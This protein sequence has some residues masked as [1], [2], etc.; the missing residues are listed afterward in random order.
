MYVRVHAVCVHEVH[1][2]VCMYAVY[3]RYVCACACA[4]MCA[5]AVCVY[6]YTCTCVRCTCIRYGYCVCMCVCV[7]LHV[8][9]PCVLCVRYTCACM[10][11]LYVCGGM[12][13]HV[14]VRAWSMC[15]C[16]Y[17]CVGYLCMHGVHLCVWNTCV[18]GVWHVHVRYVCVHVHVWDVCA[19]I[20]CVGHVCICACVGVRCVHAC[21]WGT[22]VG[23]R[24]RMHVRARGT[25]V[26]RCV[27]CVCVHCMHGIC[28]WGW[29][30]CVCGWG[31]AS[32]LKTL[33]PECVSLA[34]Q[35]PA[36]SRLLGRVRPQAKAG[37]R[38]KGM[39]ASWQGRT[40]QEG[41]AVAAA[42]AAG[43]WGW[44]CL[45]RWGPNSSSLPSRRWAA[46]L[47]FYVVTSCRSDSMKSLDLNAKVYS[48]LSEFK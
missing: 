38:Q 16:A 13:V 20:A 17:A 29:G 15:V 14:H 39:R 4:C 48:L 19:C 18:C 26:C 22:C 45:P 11:G 42:G 3:M 34:L 24:G 43:M 1:A 46:T 33:S 30:V 25:C 35:A 37:Q 10:C 2:C 32:R 7:H 6:A 9:G 21:E 31:R 5:H 12:C 8:K 47:P 36:S 41:G 40:E 23:A 28:A 44:Q 27:R